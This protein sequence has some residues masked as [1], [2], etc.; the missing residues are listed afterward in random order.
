[1]RSFSRAFGVTA[2]V[3]SLA[4]LTACG[5]SDS[6]GSKGG[7]SH[8]TVGFSMPTGAQPIQQTVAKALAAAGKH[9]D[10]DVKTLDAQLDPN[11]QVTDI[12]QFVA[13]H[14]DAIIV[15]PLSQDSLTP[16]LNRA[17]QAGIKVVGFNAI[18][19]PEAKDI[20][21]YD[22]NFD[23][24]ES[25]TGARLLAKYVGEQLHGQGNALGIGIGVP[26]PSLQLMVKNYEKFLT[27]DNP[28][29]KWVGTVENRTDDI[30]GGQQVTTDAITRNHGKIDAVL[31]YN[32]SSALGAAAAFKSAGQPTPVIVAQNGDPESVE[33][34]KDGRLSAAVD[35][36]PWRE[37]L[38]A[39]ALTKKLLDG[40]DVP[41][42]VE[43]PVELYTKDNVAKRLDWN[44]AVAKIKDGS[45][46]CA[47]G[48]C[49]SDLVAK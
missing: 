21:P 3:L 1:M 32:T 23:Q 48:G 30:A 29:V 40:D 46:T 25:I 12:N 49:P 27:G 24:G 47:N 34:I 10:I 17:R 43:T 2:A 39:I 14:V 42:W 5:A 16:A 28:N 31:S 36:V 13:Q 18:L 35:I 37:G 9:A 22:T 15:F 11:K 45:L 26:V 38:L 8:Y 41:T 7:K 33:A 4:A 44:D 19:D 20:A 6:E